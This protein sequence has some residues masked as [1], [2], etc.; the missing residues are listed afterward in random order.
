MRE[1]GQIGVGLTEALE[2]NDTRNARVP[3]RPATTGSVGSAADIHPTAGRVEERRELPRILIIP[4]RS[5]R[6][7]NYL[8]RLPHGE[9]QG[10]AP[11]SRR[12]GSRLAR[13]L[14]TG[15]LEGFVHLGGGTHALQQRV[16][17]LSRQVGPLVGRI[18]GLAV[19]P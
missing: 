7:S 12:R 10:R 6:R 18:R 5:E 8:D 19:S 4:E 13:D 17:F 15:A 1:P 14:S 2:V 3:V 9:L 16:H 11:A